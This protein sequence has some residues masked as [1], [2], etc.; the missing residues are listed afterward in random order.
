MG[1]HLFLLSSVLLGAA[2]LLSGAGAETPK[3]EKATPQRIGFVDLEAV[4]WQSHFVREL[5]EN[6]ESQVREKEAELTAILEQMQALQEEM[7]RKGPTLSDEKI[8]D[9]RR[10]GRRM[11]LEAED[12]QYEMQNLQRDLERNKMGPALNKVLQVIEE[13]GQ[14][15]GLD[16][17]LRGDMVLFGRPEWNLTDEVVKRLDADDATSGTLKAQ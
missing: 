3:P 5:V 6:M 9:M 11:Q 1:K 12:K 16:L 7:E 17:I 14:E 8:Q 4:S 10:E 15:K 13:L 2:L